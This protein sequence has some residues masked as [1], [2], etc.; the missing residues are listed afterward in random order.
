MVYFKECSD[1]LKRDVVR[2]VVSLQDHLDPHVWN[3]SYGH[4][5]DAGS[6]LK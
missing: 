6:S 4:T 5:I 1:N 3:K 2:P